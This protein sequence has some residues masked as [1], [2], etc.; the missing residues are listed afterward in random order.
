MGRAMVKN[1]SGARVAVVV[2]IHKKCLDELETA[3]VRV[4]LSNAEHQDTY[5]VAPRGLDITEYH[6]GWPE[7]E[8][9]RFA[10][11]HFRSVATYNLWMLRTDLFR[12]FDVYEFILICQTDAIL[13]RP[14]PVGEPWDFDYLGA[15]W[16]P[17][18]LTGWDD[19]NRRLHGSGSSGRRLLH[20]GNGGLSLRR[21]DVF[22][23][24]LRLPRF[25]QVPPEDRA[26]SYFAPRLGIR[27][28][29]AGSASRYFM[30]TGARGWR[31]GDPI[32]DVYGFHGLDRM[33]P[34]LE[35]AVLASRR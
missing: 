29:D 25:Q 14:L 11:R 1:R 8:V 22:R 33:N 23:R 16:V 32:P 20:V 35:R 17:P 13:H 15:P 19:A 28:A 7:V 30:E 27:V 10:R 9:L 4:S 34:E 18:M 3:R 6:D 26:I 5:F 12:R 24:R 2:P 21:T 31:P